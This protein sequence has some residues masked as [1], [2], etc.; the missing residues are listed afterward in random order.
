MTYTEAI[1]RAAAVPASLI[2]MWDATSMQVASAQPVASR[3]QHEGN[4]TRGIV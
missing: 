3:E 1:S 2:A 4:S